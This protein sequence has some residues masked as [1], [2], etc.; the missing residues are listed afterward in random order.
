MFLEEKTAEAVATREAE[1]IALELYGVEATATALPGE[2]DCNFHLQ[3]RDGREFVLKCMHPAR[4]TAFIDMQ[5]A[6]LAHLAKH[7]AH[8]PL[9][10][11]QRTHK[12]EAYTPWND[13]AGQLRLVWML[14]FLPGKTL[15]KTTPHSPELFCELG[16]FL[17][18][19]DSALGSFEH[20]AAHRELKWDSA[21]ANWICEHL[22]K[23]EDPQ[24]KALVKYFIDLFAE[25]VE[26]LQNQLRKGVIYG[27]AND[28]NVLVSAVW[29]QPRIAGVIDFGDLHHGWVASEA[30]IAAAYAILGKDDPLCASRE[31]VRGFHSAYPLNES[32]DRGNLSVDW[33][34]AGGQCGEFG[35]SQD[36]ETGR[37]VRGGQRTRRMGCAGAAGQDSS[38]VCALLACATLAGFRRCRKPENF[39]NGCAS[40]SMAGRK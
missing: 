6:A 20:S 40:K 2:Y 37:R 15:A 4:E 36:S 24:R 1:R 27:D 17:G 3:A 39:R 30:A 9:P 26:P 5:C 18:E 7:A 12:G 16:K 21:R 10:R 29:P 25:W 11:V 14:N 38:A 34:A 33:N 31:I 8:L 22:G 28:H 35:D 23:I 13:A 32:G 19:M